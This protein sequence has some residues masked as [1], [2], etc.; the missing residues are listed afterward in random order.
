MQYARTD[1]LRLL[2][3]PIPVIWSGFAGDTLSLQQNGWDLVVEHSYHDHAYR[4]IMK[5]D[6]FSCVAVSEVNRLDYDFITDPR[7]N[8]KCP[9]FYVTNVNSDIHRMNRPDGH[10]YAT[11]A[12]DATPTWE[13]RKLESVKDLNVFKV[14]QGKK[15]EQIIIERNAD[16]SVIEHL[17]EIK[18]IQAPK[19]HELRTKIINGIKATE[20]HEVV[21][22][23]IKVA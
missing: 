6:R 4:L 9:P 18:R 11:F 12:I 20:D 10:D 7:S 8:I 19:Q 23:L 17:Q 14:F 3:R 16:M 1:D 2:S 13:T 21:L 22:S 15:T 5:N